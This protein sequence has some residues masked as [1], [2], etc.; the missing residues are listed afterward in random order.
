M[1]YTDVTSPINAGTATP[2]LTFH[3]VPVQPEAN[4]PITLTLNSL[5]VTNE[6]TAGDVTVNTQVQDPAYPDDPTKLLDQTATYSKNGLG[7]A[8]NTGAGIT[9]ELTEGLTV[10]TRDTAVSAADAATISGRLGGDLALTSSEGNAISATESTA[11]ANTAQAVN[12]TLN[13]GTATIETQGDAIYA[14]GFNSSVSLSGAS[15][16][17]ITSATGSALRSE[18]GATISVRGT[19]SDTD[20]LVAHGSIT[21]KSGGS[22]ATVDVG[23]T[24]DLNLPNYRPNTRTDIWADTV[25]IENTGTGSAIENH[26]SGDL[27][28]VSATDKTGTGIT[29]RNNS[30]DNATIISGLPDEQKGLED[31]HTAGIH[32]ITYGAPLTIENQNAS[33]NAILLKNRGSLLIQM[34]HGVPAQ[35][36]GNITVDQGSNICLIVGSD[37]FIHTDKLTLTAGSMS[38][39][40]TFGTSTWSDRAGTGKTQATADGVGSLLSMQAWENSTINADAVLS[41]GAAGGFHAEDNGIRN[42]DTTLTGESGSGADRFPHSLTPM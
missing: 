21:L 4:S 35:I 10:T 31:A 18:N 30:A 17:V 25:T 24:A 36:T 33:G 23:P 28:T 13:G 42:G 15:D 12:F 9:L 16:Y 7:I 1:T 37:G 3:Y 8:T 34:D 41:G 11:G 27:L 19:G 2:D 38:D 39:I 40:A 6:T 20:G 29:L 22:A 5:T 14:S 32:I 26:R